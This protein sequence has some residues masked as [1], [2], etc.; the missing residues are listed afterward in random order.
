MDTST[1]P[2]TGR[3]VLVTGTVADL[4]RD[5]ARTAIETLGGTAAAGVTQKV[6]LIVLGEGAGISKT[7]KARALNVPVLDPAEFAALAADPTG[8]NGARLG[9]AFDIWDAANPEQA[10][11][12][13]R[14]TDRAHW[15]AKAVVHIPDT[16][17]V[18]QRQV[19]L[20][21]ACGHHWMRPLLFGNDVCPRPSS[22]VTRAPWW[23]DTHA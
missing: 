21:C 20:L 1:L 19:R 22:P 14:V 12:P 5:Q 10:P 15:V 6:D 2:L 3:T 13:V 11:E 16:D 23:P 9:V 18:I 7:S 4:S 17:G 8:W